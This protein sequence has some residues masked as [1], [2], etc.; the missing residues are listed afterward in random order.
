MV[1]SMKYNTP[2]PA[3][4]RRDISDEIWTKLALCF[5]VNKGNGE[6]LQMIIVNSS[7]QYFGFFAQVHRG[8]I[9][10]HLTE[11]GTQLQSVFVDG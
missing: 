10:R 6:G 1:F 9:Y 3:Y 5:L 4:Q 8:E 11:I 7:M 2:A